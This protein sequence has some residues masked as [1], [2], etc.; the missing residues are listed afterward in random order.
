MPIKL[1]LVF[2]QK[3]RLSDAGGATLNYDPLAPLLL[4]EFRFYMALFEIVNKEGESA[5]GET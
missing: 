5:T 3:I 4:L 1:S 2:E